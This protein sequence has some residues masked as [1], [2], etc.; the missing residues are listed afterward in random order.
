MFGS[1]I[2]DVGAGVI[3][4]FLGVSLATSAITEAITSFF[5]LRQ[6]TLVAGLQLLLNDKAG[7]GLARN[8]LNHALV[9]PLGD[10]LANN[11]AELTERPA[12]IDAQHFATGLLDVIRHQ[13]AQ[14][15]KPVA[16][17]IADIEN[18]QIKRTLQALWTQAGND[19]AKFR[20][21]I[22]D[23]FDASMER[24][25]GLYKR[26]TQFISFFV[27][28]GVA[29]L[30]NIDALH[31]TRE[32]WIHPGQAQMLAAAAAKDGATAQQ[33]LSQLETRSLISWDHFTGSDRDPSQQP[34]GFVFMIVGWLVVAGAA[35]FGA[36]F[37]FDALQRITQLRGVGG[38]AGVQARAA[39]IPTA[40]EP[41]G[42]VA[43]DATIKPAG[44]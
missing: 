31:M 24:V 7:V 26:K 36:P 42:D 40:K 32:L 25:G 43:V 18:P 38:G 34:F 2:L 29:V 35:L 37:W 41:A 21:A 28:L 23:W 27:A 1:V 16:T 9:N 22:G 44:A 15:P 12:Y 39:E 3:F 4:A 33:V 6:S 30:L 14:P 17:A 11:V 13:E 20:Q 10:G 5:K 8:L 19:E